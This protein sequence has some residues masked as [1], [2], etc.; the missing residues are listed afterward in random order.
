M[1]AQNRKFCNTLHHAPT[2]SSSTAMTQPR[3]I[4][5]PSMQVRFSRDDRTDLRQGDPRRTEGASFWRYPAY[6]E[7]PWDQAELARYRLRSNEVFHRR[8]DRCRRDL[9]PCLVSRGMLALKDAK[10]LMPATGRCPAPQPCGR[11]SAYG[12]APSRSRLPPRPEF[13]TLQA[14][15]D[16]DAGLA[17]H[18]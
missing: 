7:H 8:A 2:R 3:R 11:L 10:F 12:Q 4:W 5:P 6:P 14:R 16:A 18:T 17:L 9:V 1:R 15:S 13:Q